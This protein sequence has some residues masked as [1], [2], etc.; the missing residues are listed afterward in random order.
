MSLWGKR[1]LATVA[2]AVLAFSGI[3]QRVY[4]QQFSTGV[5]GGTLNWT[6]TYNSSRCGQYSVPFSYYNFSSF[7]FV[8][9]GTTYP[10]SGSAAYFNSPGTN[11]GCPPNGPEPS[12]LPLALPSS[13]GNC[14]IDFTPESGGQGSATTSSCGTS[15]TGYIEPKFIVIGVDYVVPGTLSFQ[16]VC[17]SKSLSTT[18][19]MQYTFSS[20]YQSDFKVSVSGGIFKFLNGSQSASYSSKATQ[21]SANSNSVTLATTSSLCVSVPGPANA[22]VPNNHDYDVIWLWLNPV[23]SFTFQENSSGSITSIAFNGYGFNAADQPE[24]DIYPAYVGCL[25]GDLS[26]SMPSLQRSW[27]TADKW[28]SGKGAALTSADYS[29]ILAMDPFAECTPQT[30]AGKQCSAELDLNPDRFSQTLNEDIPYVQPPAGGQPIT[31][32][33]TLTSTTTDTQSHGYTTSNMTTYGIEK[34]FSLGGF[35]TGISIT[36]GSSQSYSTTYEVDNALQTSNS[37]SDEV[38]ITGPPCNVV[39]NA[40]SPYYPSTSAPGP[41]EFEVLEDNVYGTFLLNPVNWYY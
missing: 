39:S 32:I 27:D 5:D 38:S 25:N 41:T 7:N 31:S 22:Y 28:P 23:E 4:A 18:H 26:C 19:T 16:D 36:A 9:G 34:S 1:I 3:T 40:C 35:L 10:L 6:V 15:Y 20:S 33:Y 17:S 29:A 8:Y 24:M 37:V 30:S 2:F 21:T 14:V 12:V 13:F 11:Q